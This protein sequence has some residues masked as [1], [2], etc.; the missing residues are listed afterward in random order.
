MTPLLSSV[1]ELVKLVAALA[2][3]AVPVSVRLWASM[4]PLFCVLAACNVISLAAS[5]P[6]LSSFC[7]WLISNALSLRITP[8]LL[9]SVAWRVVLPVAMMSPALVSVMAFSCAAF[10]DKMAPPLSLRKAR[11][12]AFASQP[13]R[14]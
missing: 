3:F 12:F 7:A 1:A 8:L 13:H 6:L 4:L 5:V 2:D 11:Q 14:P 10:C 9:T